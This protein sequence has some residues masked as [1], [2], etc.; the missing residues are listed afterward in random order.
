MITPWHSWHFGIFNMCSSAKSTWVHNRWIFSKYLCIFCTFALSDLLKMQ[1]CRKCKWF[2][3]L[4]FFHCLY[5]SG[6]LNFTYMHPCWTKPKSEEDNRWKIRTLRCRLES[7]SKCAKVP[8][9]PR[10]KSRHIVADWVE[11]VDCVLLQAVNHMTI[12][13][14]HGYAWMPHEVGDSLDIRTVSRWRSFLS[15]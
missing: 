15:R 11:G 12:F 3:I 4:L 2:S 8:R 5:N 13:L 10:G 6:W 7:P 14:R 1:K 9:M